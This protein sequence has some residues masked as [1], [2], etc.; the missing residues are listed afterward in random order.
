MKPWALP[1]LILERLR[2]RHRAASFARFLLQ[3]FLAD[4]LFQ[5]A[6][7]LAY[8]T[9]FALAPLAIVVFGVLGAFPSFGGWSGQLVD[10][11][12]S[13]FVPSAARSA[14]Q[15]LDRFLA[16]AGQL[17][18]AG[19]IALVAS[20]L[21][22]LNSIEQTF[23]H[24]WRVASARPRLSRFLVYWTVLTLGALLAA[25]S[26]AVSA[27]VLALPLFRTDEGR[28]LAEFSLLAT[29]VLIEFACIVLIYRVVPHHL[30]RW[31]HALAGGLL[32]VALLEL[33]KWGLG[34]YLGNFQSY[35]RIYGTLAILPILLLWIYLSWVAVLLG[36]SLA[37]AIAAFRYQPADMRL[38]DGYELYGL[39][40][41]LGRFQQARTLGKGLD[42]ERMQVLEP[43]LTD[44]LIQQF[45][46]ELERIGLL[47]RDEGGEWLLARDLSDVSLLELYENCQL[48]IPAGTRPLPC[49][50][51][52]LGR[53]VQAALDR[54]RLPLREL[55][56]R[57]VAD[58]Y[59]NPSGERA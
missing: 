56:A 35:Q 14:Q 12:F 16:G 38:P 43:M 48:R 59:Q 39:L 19:V 33:A 23:N 26:L 8:T 3:R 30:V 51:D 9:V 50:D 52:A 15:Y 34:A 22:T 54:L 40:R 13:N 5:A 6:G 44:A 7:S 32:A 4:R 49:R 1:R 29:P 41:L 47:R 25:A 24:I 20:L 57:P 37:S 53:T 11:V 10:Y 2:D 46:A 36:A 58:I 28:A 42:E 17:T 21:V 45:L 31:R 18:A 27:R 55:L